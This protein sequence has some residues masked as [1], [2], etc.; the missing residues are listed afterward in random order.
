MPDSI[1]EDNL[2]RIEMLE[3]EGILHSWYLIPNVVKGL[4]SALKNLNN[5]T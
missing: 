2:R 4:S 1:I 3:R 5:I